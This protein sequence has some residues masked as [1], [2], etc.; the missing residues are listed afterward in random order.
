[1][2]LKLKNDMWCMWLCNQC[3]QHEHKCF[4]SGFKI[5]YMHSFVGTGV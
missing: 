3:K 5:E 4:K 1:M 2:I